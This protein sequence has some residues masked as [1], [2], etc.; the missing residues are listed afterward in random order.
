MKE[1][2]AEARAAGKMK[3]VVDKTGRFGWRPCYYDQAELDNECEQ[4]TYPVPDK[5]I[6]R[7]PLSA[8]HG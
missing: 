3:W 7:H 6:Q 8:E 2:T 5:K 1:V 4:I